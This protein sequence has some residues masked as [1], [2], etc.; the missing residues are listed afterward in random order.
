MKKYLSILLLVLVSLLMSCSHSP[1]PN[2]KTYLKSEQKLMQSGYHWEMLAEKEASKILA[3]VSKKNEE[4][5]IEYQKDATPF[6]TAYHE[7]LI[8]KLVSNGATVVAESTSVSSI[9]SYKVQVISHNKQGLAVVDLSDIGDVFLNREAPEQ[10][11]EILIT[12]SGINNNRIIMSDS[13]IYYFFPSN[14]KNYRTEKKTIEKTIEKTFNEKT[15][16]VSEL[17]K[18]NG[19]K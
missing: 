13:Q 12:T 18:D 1:I 10:K 7:L 15:F 17:N 8:S 16:N 3:V 11:T 14:D 6:Q 9:F 4:I 5:Y 19:E 2:A